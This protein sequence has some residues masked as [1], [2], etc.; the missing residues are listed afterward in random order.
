MT[1][2]GHKIIQNKMNIY[3]IRGSICKLEFCQWPLRKP[4]HQ[5]K[6]VR[7]SDGKKMQSFVVLKTNSSN[8]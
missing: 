2:F 1:I 3:T 5:K 6:K 7:T 8:I 4:V